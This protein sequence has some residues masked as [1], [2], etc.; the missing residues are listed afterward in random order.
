MGVE[1]GGRIEGGRDM[2]V[3]PFQIG[4]IKA[5]YTRVQK[6]KPP[7]S[8]SGTAEPADLVTISA[9]AKKKILEETRSRVLERIRRTE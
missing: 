6:I 3:F 4:E 1:D 9:E 7:P 8:D 5:L 2:T